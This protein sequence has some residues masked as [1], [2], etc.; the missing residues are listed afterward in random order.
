MK[1]RRAPQSQSKRVPS[2]H[3]C[4]QVRHQ[5]ICQG[6][7]GVSPPIRLPMSP[8]WAFPGRASHL[9]WVY[10]GSVSWSHPCPASSNT[11]CTYMCSYTSGGNTDHGRSG[12]R[13]LGWGDR[14]LGILVLGPFPSRSEKQPM[15]QKGRLPMQEVLT[16]EPC[17][18]TCQVPGASGVVTLNTLSQEPEAHCSTGNLQGNIRFTPEE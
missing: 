10:L 13:A 16:R 2:C 17:H 7:G 9:S 12:G 18:G 6:T 5:A 1:Y 15:G 11:R 8:S 14:V 4:S 3:T